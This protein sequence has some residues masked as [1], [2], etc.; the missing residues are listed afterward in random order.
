MDW[1]TRQPADMPIAATARAHHPT[2][3][4][5]SFRDF[6]GCGISALNPFR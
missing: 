3:V 6:E 2:L 4:T 5:R 1:K